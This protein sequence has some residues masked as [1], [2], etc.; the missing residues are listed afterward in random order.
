MRPG[1]SNDRAEGSRQRVAEFAALVDGS[2]DTRVEVT[3]ESARPREA[4]HEVVDAL[5]IRRE[6][7]IEVPQA[8]FQVSVGEIRRRAV[9]RTGHEQEVQVVGEDQPVQ[10]RVD[11]I[12]SGAGA[13]MTQQPVLDVLGP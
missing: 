1:L 5:V 11:E 12:D 13:P 3:R 6:F 8:A 10:V 7:G 4:S 2:R 9:A